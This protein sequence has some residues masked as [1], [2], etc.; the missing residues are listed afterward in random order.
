MSSSDYYWSRQLVQGAGKMWFLKIPQE[1]E[2]N[3]G[4]ASLLGSVVREKSGQLFPG[5]SGLNIIGKDFPV[6]QHVTTPQLLLNRILANRQALKI[7]ETE[8]IVEEIALAGVD[9]LVIEKSDR[10]EADIGNF[11]SLPVHL[12]IDYGRMERITLQLGSNTRKRYIL[13]GYLKR[14]KDS[15]GNDDSLITTDVSID[16]ETIIDEI[17]LTDRYSVT[18]ESVER[19]SPKFKANAMQIPAL[20]AGTVSVDFEQASKKQ[21]TI[22]VDNGKDYLIALKDVDWDDLS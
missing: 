13:R 1:A 17:L 9:K 5:G 20:S 3:S 8:N 11:P 15:V 14:L 10:L 7:P 19:F 21:V 6:P 18:F 4:G 16:K 2:G 12:E 22:T